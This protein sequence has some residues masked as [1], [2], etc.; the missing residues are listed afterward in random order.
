MANFAVY[1]WG[2]FYMHTYKSVCNFVFINK[3][4]KHTYCSVLVLCSR[5]ALS[6]A[7]WVRVFRPVCSD[8]F[9][10]PRHAAFFSSGSSDLGYSDTQY[11]LLAYWNVSTDWIGKI[12]KYF[13]LDHGKPSI[14]Q[15]N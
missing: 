10:P 5:V 3:G 13:M 12:T 9:E 14:L 11:T 4:L 15:R 2:H 6:T 1:F 7:F 8:Y